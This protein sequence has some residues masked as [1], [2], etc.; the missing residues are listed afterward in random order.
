[1]I[2]TTVTKI[3]W[4]RMM[5]IKSCGRN[6]ICADRMR[7]HLLKTPVNIIDEAFISFQIIETKNEYDKCINSKVKNNI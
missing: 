2:P 5:N 4:L 6:C 1:M 3:K 7:R